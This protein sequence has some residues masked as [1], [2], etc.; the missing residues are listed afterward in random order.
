MYELMTAYWPTAEADPAA[1]PV[2]REY[3]RIWS[4]TPKVVFSSTLSTV[5]W[6]SRLVR[7]DVGGE[8]ARLRNEFEGDLDIGGAT[9]AAAFIRRGLVD[10]YRLV[11]HP[12]VLGAGTPYFPPLES[13]LPLRLTETRTFASG[14]VYLGY[15]AIR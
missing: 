6:N 15:A 7:G 3:A 12:V 9:L 8:L 4:A 2:E 11:V 1:T 13:P 5:G 14:S 10:E